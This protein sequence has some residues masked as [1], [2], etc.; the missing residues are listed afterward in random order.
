MTHVHVR[1]VTREELLRRR[2]AILA[3]LGVEY[4]EL[5]RR[6]ESY[7]L[8]GDEWSAWDRLQEIEF[9]LGDEG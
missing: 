9:L 7:S 2:E 1:E 4:D 3:R 5:A 6:A 8:A